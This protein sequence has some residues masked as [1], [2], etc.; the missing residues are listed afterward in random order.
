ME[1]LQR[2]PNNYISESSQKL[3]YYNAMDDYTK[4][5]IKNANKD[6][7]L[8]LN[9]IMEIATNHAKF[10]GVTSNYISNYHQ[11]NLRNQLLRH[12]TAQ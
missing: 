1:L 6:D 7:Q 10:K 3:Y 12:L 11:V 4:M 2:V 8:T 9:Q 5:K